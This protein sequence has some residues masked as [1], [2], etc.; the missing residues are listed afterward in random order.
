[1]SLTVSVAFPLL[2][3]V[4]VAVAVVPVVTLPNARFP[5]TPM[6]RVGTGVPVPDAASVLLPLVASEF[7]VTVPL[8]VVSATG[9]N[10]TVTFVKPPAAIAPDQAPLNPLG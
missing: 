7:T 3:I 4:I 6:I 1:M 8:Y 10:V 9:A 5:L 2:V